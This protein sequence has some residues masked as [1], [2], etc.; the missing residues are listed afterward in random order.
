MQNQIKQNG[1]RV[2]AQNRQ[3]LGSAG[4]QQN[5]F[6]TGLVQNGMNSTGPQFFN[7]TGPIKIPHNK[8]TMP[9]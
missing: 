4:G 7:K 5:K 9:G 2:G 6:H 8:I 3:N 1:L